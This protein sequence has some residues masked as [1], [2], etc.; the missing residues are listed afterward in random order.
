MRTARAHQPANQEAADGR[1]VLDYDARQKSRFKAVLEG[2]EELAVML[3]RGTVLADGDRLLTDDGASIEVIASDEDLSIA[4]TD[5]ALLLTRAAYHLGNRHVPLR[6][7]SN[8]VAYR[9]DHVLDLMMRRLGLI[10]AFRRAP[11]TPEP[12]V[13]GHS[14]S[15]GHEHRHSHAEDEHSHH[16]HDR[17]A[18]EHSHGERHDR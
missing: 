14:P 17:P 13:Y 16:D 6:I 12:G 18:H 8:S 15:G 1:L 2:G 3:P 9:H 7:S 4:S 10:V 11:F 5:D